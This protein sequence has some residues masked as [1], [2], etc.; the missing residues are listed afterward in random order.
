MEIPPDQDVSSNIQPLLGDYSKLPPDVHPYIIRLKPENESS[1]SVQGRGAIYESGIAYNQAFQQKLQ[2]WLQQE[3]LEDQVLAIGEP[4]AFPLVALLGTPMVAEK[5]AA[6][7][8]VE[9]VVRDRSD[10]ELR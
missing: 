8:E 9:S 3:G 2:Q 6:L 7:P 4:T 5:I 1:K 10:I